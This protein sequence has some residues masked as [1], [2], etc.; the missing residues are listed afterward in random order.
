[1]GFQREQVSLGSETL[2]TG[3]AAEMRPRPP[4]QAPGGRDN[5]VAGND[6]RDGIAAVGLPDRARAAASHPCD[7]DV[8]TG[9]AMRDRAQRLP[10]ALSIG[11]AGRGERK[12]KD[13]KLTIEIGVQLVA[14]TPQQG[15]VRLIPPPAPVDGNDAPGVLGNGEVADRRMQGKLW[16]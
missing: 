8:R 3:I 12:V 6:D 16:Q 5:P 4:T 15:C 1:V 9:F 13:G 10:H 2:A 14:G 11:S 7:V